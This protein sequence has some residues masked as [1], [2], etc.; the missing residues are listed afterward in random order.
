MEII[1]TDGDHLHFQIDSS[2]SLQEFLNGQLEID[3]ITGLHYDVASRKVT[4]DWNVWE[5]CLQVDSHWD[6]ALGL[7]ALAEL[8]GV[9][10]T[11]DEPVAPTASQ[12]TRVVGKGHAAVPAWV[13][14]PAPSAGQHAASIR[15]WLLCRRRAAVSLQLLVL[16]IA[17]PL[18]GDLRGRQAVDSAPVAS[19]PAVS[20]MGM[21]IA[22]VEVLAA[23][24]LLRLW[25]GVF[26]EYLVRAAP[27]V[28]RPG[29]ASRSNRKT[30]GPG[31]RHIVL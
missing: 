29:W 19:G 7:R 16:F 31:R 28:Q 26:L 27:A 17:F 9:P 22:L 23:G 6:D 3:R 12:R 10:W 2:G 4:V 13:A 5:F 30:S 14:A 18:A 24:S 1:D 11:G 8:A 20:V 21:A 15:C 25:A